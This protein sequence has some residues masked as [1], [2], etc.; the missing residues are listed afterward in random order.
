MEVTESLM[1]F[2]INKINKGSNMAMFPGGT[3]N[4]KNLRDVQPLKSGLARIALGVKDP[5]N[6]LIVPLGFSYRKDHPKRSP[7]AVV[8]SPIS[9]QGFDDKELLQV[10]RAMIQEAVSEAFDITE[11]YIL[12]L[13]SCC[14]FLIILRA[15]RRASASSSELENILPTNSPEIALKAAKNRL[16]SS[17][18]ESLIF[19]T[20]YDCLPG[21]IIAR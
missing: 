3:R 12:Y 9:P 7:V 2:N 16:A 4:Q 6:L 14:A 17:I 21:S 15:R 1:R 19:F 5:S 13:V 20:V 10:T 18:C 11:K 8:P